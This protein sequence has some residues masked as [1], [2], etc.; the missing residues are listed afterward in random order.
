MKEMVTSLYYEERDALQTVLETMG[1]I[2]LL[3]EAGF[4][5]SRL[6]PIDFVTPWDFNISM[7]LFALM[8]GHIL[9]DDNSETESGVEAEEIPEYEDEEELYEVFIPLKKGYDAESVEEVASI[10]IGENLFG[11]TFEENGIK[12]VFYPGELPS[13]RPLATAEFIVRLKEICEKEGMENA[14]RP[15]NQ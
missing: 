4:D 15:D 1:A 8:E 12:L 9:S 3:K 7:E 11:L 13:P 2:K 5:I 10:T 14:N 6:S